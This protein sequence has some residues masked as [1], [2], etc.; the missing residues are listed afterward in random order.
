[1]RTS[2]ADGVAN[3][4]NLVAERNEARTRAEKAE[5]ALADMTTAAAETDRANRELADALEKARAE[6]AALR[7][8]LKPF[9]VE[10]ARWHEMG[11]TRPIRT[12]TDITVGDLRRARALTGGNDG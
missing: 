2:I 9:G 5:A 3:L 8:A 10:A 4:T 7:E 1:M 11:D 6:A 12:D